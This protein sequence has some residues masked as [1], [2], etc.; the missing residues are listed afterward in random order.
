MKYYISYNLNQELISWIRAITW[1]KC[2]SELPNLVESSDIEVYKVVEMYSRD[3]NLARCLQLLNSQGSNFHQLNLNKVSF[4]G[5][6]NLFLGIKA[7]TRMSLFT[8][9]L[10]VFIYNTKIV[11]T[12]ATPPTPSIFENYLY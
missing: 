9:S 3:I 11:N 7:N 2:N 12:W 1:S 5:F 6:Y 8:I 4:P 10:Y